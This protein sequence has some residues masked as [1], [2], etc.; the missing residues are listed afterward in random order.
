L[1]KPDEIVHAHVLHRGDDVPFVEGQE[2]GKN[3]GKE[4]KQEQV[5]KIGRYH[6][7]G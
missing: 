5:N 1:K 6:Q 4:D 3:D 7:V 2:Y